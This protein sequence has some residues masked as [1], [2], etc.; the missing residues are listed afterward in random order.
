MTAAELGR[1]L[2]LDESRLIGINNRNLKTLGVDLADHPGAA[3]A[4]GV[5]PGRVLVS[6]SGLHSSR[7]ISAYR[8]R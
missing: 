4:G 5:P 2:A 7:A 8:T 1:A 3:G 6:E